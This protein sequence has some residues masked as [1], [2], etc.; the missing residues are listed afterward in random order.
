MRSK[1]SAL[2]EHFVLQLS[3]VYLAREDQY[4][5]ANVFVFPVWP[6]IEKL[7][8]RFPD[9]SYGEGGFAFTLRHFEPR[10]LYERKQINSALVLAWYSVLFRPAN[11][12]FERKQFIAQALEFSPADFMDERC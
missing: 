12:R 3:S 4:E 6:M 11:L 10:R 2:Y 5:S 7:I 9:F 8:R 1:T